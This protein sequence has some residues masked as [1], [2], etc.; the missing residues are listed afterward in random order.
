MPRK[1]EPVEV[2]PVSNED[3]LAAV[4]SAKVSILRGMH[5][6]D[7]VAGILLALVD[8]INRQ[9]DIAELLETQAWLDAEAYALRINRI[10]NGEGND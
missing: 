9:C 2:K 3:I 6:G 7:K 8:E 10:K 1:K 4:K 5:S